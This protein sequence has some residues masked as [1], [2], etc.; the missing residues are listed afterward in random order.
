MSDVKYCICKCDF[1][2]E[3]IDDFIF[4]EGQSA[5]YTTDYIEIEDEQIKFYSF[6]DTVSLCNGS[7]IKSEYGSEFIFKDFFKTITEQEYNK[8]NRGAKLH[9]LKKL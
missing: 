8:I 5:Y 3:A 4:K 2:A 9:F 6:F 7:N 1:I